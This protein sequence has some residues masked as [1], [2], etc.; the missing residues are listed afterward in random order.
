MVDEGFIRSVERVTTCLQSERIPY[1][2]TG[3]VASAIYGEPVTS[4]DVDIVMSMTPEQAGRLAGRLPREFNVDVDMLR[5]AAAER[6]MANVLDPA[7]GLK[8]D[9][10]VLQDTPYY[11]E[12]LRRRLRINYP[13]SAIMVWMV[14][15]E[16]IVLMKLAWR[17]DTGSRK[18]WEN[19]LSVVR[20]QRNRLDWGTCEMGHGTRVASDLENMAARR[21]SSGQATAFQTR[22]SDAGCRHWAALAHRARGSAQ[23]P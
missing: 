18:Q 15:A 4:L 20:T 14:S 3:S 19:A 22:R 5:R 23:Q 2:I 9:L 6:S 16:D 1:A 17:K 8:F 10:S 21:A 13:G 11:R 12:V 7:S